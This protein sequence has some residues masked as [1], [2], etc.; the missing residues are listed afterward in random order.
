MLNP[1][2]T[3]H[4]LT[5]LDF[6]LME[7]PVLLVVPASGPPR[8]MLPALEKLKLV[9]VP[10]SLGKRPADQRQPAFKRNVT[11]SVAAALTVACRRYS[12]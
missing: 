6:H 7:R 4:Y 3:M 11:A 1:G 5:G 9:A 8:M 12:R 10:Y 2:P